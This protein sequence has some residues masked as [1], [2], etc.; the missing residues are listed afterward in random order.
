MLFW[1]SGGKLVRD[2]EV[3]WNLTECEVESL[4]QT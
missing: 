2:S 1:E 4:R 3:D